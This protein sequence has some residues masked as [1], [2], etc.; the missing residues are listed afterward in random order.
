MRNLDVWYAR[1]DDRRQLIARA[2]QATAPA[3]WPSAPRRRIAKA[4]TKDSLQAFAKLTHEV[5][6]EPRIIATRR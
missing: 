6:G 5:D 3:S 4:R 2:T 1:L